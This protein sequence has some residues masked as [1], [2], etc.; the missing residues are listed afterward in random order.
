MMKS[1]AAS[2]AMVAP[3]RLVVVDVAPWFEVVYVLT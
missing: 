1:P 3:W 2:M